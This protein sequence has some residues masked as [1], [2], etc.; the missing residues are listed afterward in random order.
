[1]PKVRMLTSEA[2][3]GFSRQY[4]EIVEMR[5]EEA[6]AAIECGKAELVRGAEN[7]KAELRPAAAGTGKGKRNA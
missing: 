5:G 1:M 7:E 2:G 4:G 3:D 6:E